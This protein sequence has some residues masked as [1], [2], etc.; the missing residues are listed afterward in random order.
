[1]STE[2]FSPPEANTHETPIQLTEKQQRTLGC[3]ACISDCG[4]SPATE[5]NARIVQCTGLSRTTVHANLVRLQAMALID[6]QPR[7]RKPLPGTRGPSQNEHWVTKAGI[8]SLPEDWASCISETADDP[9]AKLTVLQKSYLRCI[10]CLMSQGIEPTNN[11]IAA[12]NTRAPQVT[13]Y[14]LSKIVNQ[15]LLT[16]ESPDIAIRQRGGKAPV[17]FRPTERTK[18][19]MPK[20]PSLLDCR[21]ISNNA[22]KLYNT[23]TEIQRKALGCVACL[24][25][26]VKAGE[27]DGVEN[28]LVSAC[29][30]IEDVSKVTKRFVE[31]GILNM[32][33]GLNRS[34]NR[35]TYTPTA[36][37]LS[38]FPQ[39]TEVFTCKASYSKGV[40]EKPI[41]IESAVAK[42]LGCIWSRQIALEE[43][44]AATTSMVAKC[45]GLPLP[46]V[47]AT[48]KLL[49]DTER[50]KR[51]MTRYNALYNLNIPTPTYSPTAHLR[52]LPEIPKD[53]QLLIYA[54]IPYD[55]IRPLSSIDWPAIKHNTSSLEDSGWIGPL[56]KHSILPA[57]EE[58]RLGIIIQNSSDQKEI[59]AA[60]NKFVEH[61]S[62][63]VVS[64]YY[65]HG[66]ER[67]F[68]PF[69]DALLAGLDGVRHAATKFD[70]SMGVKFSTYATP[71]IRQ[72]IT[73]EAAR[74]NAIPTHDFI[75]LPALH[76]TIKNFQE[77]FRKWPSVLEI[78]RELSLTPRAV[79]RILGRRKHAINVMDA[80]LDAAVSD[81]A[82]SEDRYNFIKA[83]EAGYEEV[84][85][86]EGVK[87]LQRYLSPVE[88]G[89]LYDF[90]SGQ[91]ARP[92][93][94]AE[95][96]KVPAAQIR[97]AR[98]RVRSLLA[99]PFFGVMASI[100]PALGWQEAAACLELDYS[101]VIQPTRSTRKKIRQVCASCP[102]QDK[103]AA[104]AES[105][106][107]KFTHAYW[108]GKAARPLV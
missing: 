37:G 48:M 72:R 60:I 92:K 27:I 42:C 50:V 7:T 71:W 28:S 44:P 34:A 64:V 43:A 56:L 31:V 101:P 93:E 2:E 59:D 79:Q 81:E 15:G 11:E 100:S 84:N 105:A 26:K 17:S 3:L 104:F 99:H 70:P 67:L 69:S 19:L 74:T 22:N 102:V 78:A 66:T 36:V 5:S 95:A 107:P 9:F 25:G 30:G 4:E 77:T 91:S 94:I 62:R 52:K 54:D 73:L 86:F 63:L 76:H 88:R 10:S 87:E 38:I 51:T 53:C 33:D 90:V 14:T 35:R 32:Q 68:L 61:N 41:H 80:G 108:G 89:I 75:M 103:C 24:H 8:K 82:G 40:I 21:L 55:I 1:M 29:T 18:D 16:K 47:Q 6:A 65:R 96:Y 85:L 12:C 97:H 58:V 46:R 13:R 39:T 83:D 98:N 45:S 57:E 49:V 23:L 20:A 106:E